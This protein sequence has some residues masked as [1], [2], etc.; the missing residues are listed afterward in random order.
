MRRGVL[1]AVLGQVVMVGA[2]VRRSDCQHVSMCSRIV[3][4]SKH[5]VSAIE[6]SRNAGQ[7][8]SVYQSHDQ[9]SW[10]VY[11][12]PLQDDVYGDYA[13]LWRDKDDP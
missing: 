8:M 3:G 11:S 7:S 1:G 6:T 12:N 4:L 13:G 10:T 9:A 2:Y 5:Q